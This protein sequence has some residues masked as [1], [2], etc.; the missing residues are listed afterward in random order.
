MIRRLIVLCGAF[1]LFLAHGCG[2]KG[3]LFLPP[4]Q[5]GKAGS[6]E[7]PRNVD[8]P[9]AEAAGENPE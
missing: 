8:P 2:Q 7:A 6:S 1:A 5:T 3:P 4:A 9:Q